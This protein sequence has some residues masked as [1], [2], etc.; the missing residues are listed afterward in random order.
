MSKQHRY[1]LSLTYRVN[2]NHYRSVHIPVY[3]ACVGMEYPGRF[4]NEL[5]SSSIK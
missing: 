2:V 3:S 5:V 1:Y 4:Q